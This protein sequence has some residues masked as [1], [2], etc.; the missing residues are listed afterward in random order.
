MT[1]T[2]ASPITDAVATVRRLDDVDVAFSALVDRVRGTFVIGDL[3][4]ARATTLQGLVIPAGCGVGGKCLALKHPVAVSDYIRAPDITHQFDHAVGAEGLRAVLAVPFRVD[5]EVRGVVYGAS[6][7]AIRYSERFTSVAESVVRRAEV[8][9]ATQ[10][11]IDRLAAEADRRARLDGGTRVLADLRELHAEL[12]A[13]AAATGEPSVQERL[14]GLC[15]RLTGE[16]PPAVPPPAVKLSPRE[17]DVLAQVA[18][19]CGNAEV[20]RRLSIRLDTVKSYLK[21][22]MSKLDC[23]NGAKRCSR[24]VGRACCRDVEAVDG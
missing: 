11:E 6:R 1:G 21:S 10:R 5:G 16:G 7:R 9:L 17:I 2:T 13:I 3:L 14:H 20:A 4:G 12:R 19:G 23:H 24:P 18:V 8:A 22:A 15:L